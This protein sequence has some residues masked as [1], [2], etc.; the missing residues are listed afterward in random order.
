[1]DALENMLE[2]LD[3]EV[4]K[5]DRIGIILVQV[6]PSGRD[7][8]GHHVGGDQSR[9]PLGGLTQDKN[10]LLVFVSFDQIDK[11]WSM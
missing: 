3:H 11:T 8:R 9:F 6:D 7:L 1:M 5:V 2:G 4:I 10:Q